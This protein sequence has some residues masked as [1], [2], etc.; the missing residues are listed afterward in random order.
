[1]VE[2]PPSLC[3]PAEITPASIEQ[4]TRRAPESVRAVSVHRK[5]FTRG[6]IRTP[7]TVPTATPA[8]NFFAKVILIYYCRCKMLELLTRIP[9]DIINISINKFYKFAWQPCWYYLWWEV[10][11]HLGSICSSTTIFIRRPNLVT[12]TGLKCITEAYLFLC[13]LRSSKLYH[14][15]HEKKVP[16]RVII[17]S[18]HINYRSRPQMEP[19]C[20][21]KKKKKL[22]IA[23]GEYT[24]QRNRDMSDW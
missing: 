8:G 23:T 18:S 5:F 22:R 15:K 4:E 12:A 7:F 20:F 17:L 19:R 2:L 3:N 6:T 9:M 13:C 21:S 14:S 1:V 11:K 24:F 10:K 16:I